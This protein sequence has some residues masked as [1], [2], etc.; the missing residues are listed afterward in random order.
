MYSRR[1]PLGRLQEIAPSISSWISMQTSSRRPALKPK[2]GQPGNPPQF[3]RAPHPGSS[4]GL[5][6]GRA[7]EC[8]PCPRPYRAAF[9]SVKPALGEDSNSH[10]GGCPAFGVHPS[11]CLLPPNTLKRGH[12]TNGRSKMRIAGARRTVGRILILPPIANGPGRGVYAASRFGSPQANRFVCV[13]S[14][15]EAA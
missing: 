4:A 8:L 7:F 11:G 12:Q 5:C 9:P 10:F 13:R 1:R 15:I 6:P 3:R 2:E 14:D